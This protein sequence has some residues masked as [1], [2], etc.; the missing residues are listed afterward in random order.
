MK[1]RFLFVLLVLLPARLLFAQPCGYPSVSLTSQADVDNLATNYPGCTELNG[2]DMHGTNVSNLNGLSHITYI[3]RIALSNNPQLQDLTGLSA[4]KKV[5]TLQVTDGGVKSLLGLTALDT[6]GHTLYIRSP[7]HDFKGLGAVKV[8]GKIFMQG[9]YPAPYA[10]NTSFEGFDSLDSI[11]TIELNTPSVENFKGLEKV[12]KLGTLSLL[13]MWVMT[14]LEGLENVKFSKG[15]AI[16]G[17]GALQNCGV[18]SVCMWLSENGAANLQDNAAICNTTQAI[19]SSPGCLVVFPVELISFTGMIS[20]EGNKLLWRTS[21]ETG[22]KGFAIERSTNAVAFEEIGFVAGSGD[23]KSNKDY[24]FTDMGAQGTAYYRLKQIDWDGTSHYSKIIV[25][26]S[27]SNLTRVYPNPA[28]GYLHIDQKGLNRN[29]AL[30]NRQGFVVMES[31]VLSA[32][33]LDVS[34]LPDDLYM[35]KVGEESFKVVVKNK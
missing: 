1:T 14:G 18:K 31:A 16:K 27:A 23:S 19:L 20:P 30:I 2:I 29:F 26:K 24:I 9:N 11:G 34:H 10:Y 6:I 7:L 12:K 28:K 25:V 32:G 13:N 17:S 22:N 3:G 21:W 4:L 33:K 5:E 8:I 15:I 35:L